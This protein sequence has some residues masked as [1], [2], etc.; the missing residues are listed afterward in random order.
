MVCRVF[1]CVSDSLWKPVP[2]HFFKKPRAIFIY[3]TICYS[4]AGEKSFCTEAKHDT[5][6]RFS[7]CVSK[8]LW[9]KLVARSDSVWVAVAQTG[10]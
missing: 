8:R 9:M 4:N 7:V 6:W 3:S 1:V 10:E 5:V 2:E